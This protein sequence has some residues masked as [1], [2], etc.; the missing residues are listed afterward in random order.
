MNTTSFIDLLY[1]F[2]PHTDIPRPSTID[3]AYGIRRPFR[4]IDT[5][6]MPSLEEQIYQFRR[7]DGMAFENI[8]KFSEA[9]KLAYNIK[10]VKNAQILAALKDKV[11]G[12]RFHSV[13]SLGCFKGPFLLT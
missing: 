5:D 8:T 13:A 3:T 10:K 6:T 1:T 7:T 2:I 4:H 12:E 9:F 11:D